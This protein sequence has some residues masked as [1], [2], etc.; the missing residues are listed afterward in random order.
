MGSVEGTGEVLADGASLRGAGVNADLQEPGGAVDVCWGEFLGRWSVGVDKEGYFDEVGTLPLE[1]EKAECGEVVGGRPGFHVGA[2]EE[3]DCE[4]FG[5]GHGHDPA[6]CGAM[7]G[8][9]GVAEVGVVLDVEDGVA[10]VV[11]ESVAV[12]GGVRDVLDL[13]SWVVEGIG[14]NGADG[15]GGEVE[16]TGRE[17]A[18]CVVWIENGGPGE[19]EALGIGGA[20]RDG[21]RLVFPVIEVSRGCVAPEQDGISLAHSLQRSKTPSFKRRH[22]N[23]GFQPRAP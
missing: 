2:G 1:P 20:W 22:T 13:S 12:V 8:N 18:R 6:V 15:G 21:D 11:G 17:E 19:D 7:E 9:V 4:E 10:A 14:G 3:A 23:A 16:G 5:P